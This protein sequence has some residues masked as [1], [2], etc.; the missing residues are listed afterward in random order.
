MNVWCCCSVTD[1]PPAPLVAYADDPLS[2]QN[3]PYEL[4]A[5]GTPGS[6]ATDEWVTEGFVM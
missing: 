1:R 5:V 3:S 2:P 4:H 6:A